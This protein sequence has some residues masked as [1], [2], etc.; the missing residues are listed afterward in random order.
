MDIPG[1]D[2]SYTPLKTNGITTSTKECIMQP[3]CL[4]VITAAKDSAFI[5]KR[6]DTKTRAVLRPVFLM[7]IND[8]HYAY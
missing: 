5:N 8:V 4:A 2:L 1:S 3:C 6:N 7:N